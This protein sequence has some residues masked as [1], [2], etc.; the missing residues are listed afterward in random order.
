MPYTLRKSRLKPLYWVVNR[1]TGHKFSK[2]PLTLKKAKAQ[3]IALYIA[4]RM[5]AKKFW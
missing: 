1:K 5:G 3:R 2:K 4:E